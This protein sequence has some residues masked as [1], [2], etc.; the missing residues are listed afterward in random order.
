MNAWIPFERLDERLPA[1]REDSLP[2]M[3]RDVDVS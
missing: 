2:R 1:A 3:L